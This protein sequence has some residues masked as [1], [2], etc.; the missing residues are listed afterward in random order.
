MAQAPAEL[1]TALNAP[2]PADR[3]KAAARAGALIESGE[4]TRVASDE[5]NNHIHTIYSFSPYSPAL[6]AFKAW[7]A[8]LKAVGSMDHDSVAAAMEMHAAGKAIGIATT[9]GCEV[10][11]NLTGTALEGRKVNNPD[12]ANIAYIALHGIPDGRL[13]EVAEFLKPINAARNRRNREQVEGLNRLL[14]GT[15]LS[16]LDFDKDVLAISKAEEG[17]GVTE[18]HILYALAKRIIETAGKGQGTIEFLKKR[19]GLTLPQKVEVFLADRENPHYA[20]DLLGVMKSAFLPRFFIQPDES[21]CVPVAEAI[22]LADRI[23]AIAAYAY[24]GDVAESPTGD[25]KAEKF[26]DDFLD[27]L[28]IELKR[29]GFKAVTYMPPRNTKAQLAR[30]SKLCRENSLM[31]ISG[32]DI[33]SSRQSFTCPEVM[34][35]DFSHL[36]RATWALIAHERLATADGRYALFSGENPWRDENLAARIERYARYGSAM[37]PRDPEG[38]VAMLDTK[39]RTE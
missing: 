31:E 19:L 13:D 36:I 26:E 9:A 17:G 34:D 11:V 2:D 12:S 38:I 20:Y 8:G 23:G 30:L 29:I 33:N 15:G 21:E 7:E 27:E 3:L 28:I 37:D 4:I 14:R 10:R 35:P 24:L 16:P 32:V 18:R 5:V 6:A 22:Q 1:I 39:E 25:K